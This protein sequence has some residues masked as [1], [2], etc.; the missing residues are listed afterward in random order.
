M[1]NL[2]SNKCFFFNGSGIS[3]ELAKM[4]TMAPNVDRKRT[5]NKYSLERVEMDLIIYSGE[6]SQILAENWDLYHAKALENDSYRISF[7]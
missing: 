1:G 5:K 7:L 2:L 6:R 3:R 4:C